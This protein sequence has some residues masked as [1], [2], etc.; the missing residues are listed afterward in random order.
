MN[1]AGVANRNTVPGPNTAKERLSTQKLCKGLGTHL[2][3]GKKIANL[4]IQCCFSAKTGA[5]LPCT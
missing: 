2:S 3:T 5:E 1:Q 4:G